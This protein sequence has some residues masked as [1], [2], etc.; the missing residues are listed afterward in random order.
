MKSV[1]FGELC[2]LSDMQLVFLSEMSLCF[3]LKLCFFLPDVALIV[4]SMYTSFHFCLW[5]FFFPLWY[6]CL[7]VFLFYRYRFFRPKTKLLT[8]E[9]YY[10]EGSVETKKALDELRSYC[11][12][13]GCDAW[14]T[15]SRLTSPSKWVQLSLSFHFYFR[16]AKTRLFRA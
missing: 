4:F 12:S 9:E 14:K 13:P 1:T 11:H 16:L 3:Y 6:H 5:H 8:E 15:I 10:N 7:F 2:F